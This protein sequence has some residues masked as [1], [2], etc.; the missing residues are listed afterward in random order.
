MAKK[1]DDERVAVVMGT[2]LMRYED[3]QLRVGDVVRMTK[4]DAA[5]YI[6]LRMARYATPD[7]AAK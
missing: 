1:K 7:E 6:A 3:R 5:D 2:G 4:R